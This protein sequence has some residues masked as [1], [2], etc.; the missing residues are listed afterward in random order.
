MNKNIIFQ[1]IRIKVAVFAISFIFILLLYTF[2]LN[3]FSKKIL[4]NI[5]EINLL[6]EKINQNQI[7]TEQE[8]QLQKIKLLIE[9]KFNKDMPAILFDLNKKFNKDFEEIKNLVLDKIKQENWQ[10]IQ[11]NFNQE[12]KKLNFIFQIP[13]DDFD[14]FY[15][16]LIKE[17]LIWQINNIKI[18]KN[19]NLWQIELNLQSS[20]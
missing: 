13:N 11:T 16:F 20:N 3:L 6:K 15:N 12:T 8:N 1:N 7:I 14:K 9:Q 5:N 2:L 18:E 4:N 10:I 17:Y 19:N